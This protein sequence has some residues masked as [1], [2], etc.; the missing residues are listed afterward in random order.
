[1]IIFSVIS[2]DYIV[3]LFILYI[4][5]EHV[6]SNR[7]RLRFSC[8]RPMSASISLFLPRVNSSSRKCYLTFVGPKVW[9]SIPGDI[10]SSITFTFKWKLKKHLLHEKDTQL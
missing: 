7:N 3:I 2:V 10:M 6:A 5:I 8:N 4:V 1:V 9:S